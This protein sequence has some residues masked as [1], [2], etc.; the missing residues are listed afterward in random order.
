[1]NHT[2]SLNLEMV[3]PNPE[4]SARKKFNRSAS[5]APSHEVKVMVV[6]LE[7]M[8]DSRDLCLDDL[9]GETMTGVE[10]ISGSLPAVKDV[11]VIFIQPLT[12]G[13]LRIK[14]QGPIVK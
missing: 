14:M 13:L 9:L 10:V 6:W 5:S 2:T 7:R 11:F 12:N 8:E 3:N 1:M 4:A